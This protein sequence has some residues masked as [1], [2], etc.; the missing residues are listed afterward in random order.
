[1]SSELDLQSTV[2]SIQ[3]ALPGSAAASQNLNFHIIV[4]L[5]NN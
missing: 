4:L 1:M 5:I 3:P 2:H